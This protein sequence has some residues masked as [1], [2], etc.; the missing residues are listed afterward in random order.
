[1]AAYVSEGK[2]IPRRGNIIDILPGFASVVP[3]APPSVTLGFK[4]LVQ[5]AAPQGEWIETQFLMMAAAKWW[6]FSQLQK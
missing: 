4:I 5:S 3:W 6:L 2:R 1:M